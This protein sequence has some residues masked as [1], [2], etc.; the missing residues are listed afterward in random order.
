MCSAWR[1]VRPI[2]LSGAREAMLTDWA[3]VAAGSALGGVLRFVLAGWLMRLT[4]TAFPWG[5]LA[6]NV[7][8][9]ALIGVLAVLFP[10][11]ERGFPWRLFWLPGLCGGFTTFSA[12]SLESYGLWHTGAGDKALLYVGASLIFCLVAVWAGITI[13]SRFTGNSSY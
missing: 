10:P 7:A 11:T 4:G 8:G 6:V 9:C 3:A 1:R 12:F 13:G 2:L 5:T